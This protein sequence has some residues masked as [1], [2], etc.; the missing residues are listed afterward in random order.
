MTRIEAILA[1]RAQKQAGG[2]HRK[3]VRVT[4]CDLE[5]DVIELECGHT[6]K[7][8]ESSHQLDESIRD[9]M[10]K[11]GTEKPILEGEYCSTCAEEWII[12]NSDA[13]AGTKS[14]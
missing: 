2:F 8:T 9:L 5:T 11:V 4:P 7:Q 3:I 10:R 13:G 14:K 1:A 12:G 6:R